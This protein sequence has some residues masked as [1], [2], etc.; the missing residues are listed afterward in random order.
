MKEGIFQQEARLDLLKRVLQAAALYE[1]AGAVKESDAYNH[2]A[3]PW[4]ALG[5]WRMF[6]EIR[7]VVYEY[8][9]EARRLALWQDR[10]DNGAWNVQVD[11]GPAEKITCAF[12]NEGF[13]LLRQGNAQTHAYVQRNEREMQV[14]LGGY[15]YRL[16]RRRP[17]DVNTAGHGG[18]AGHAQEA[19]TAPMAG[20][21]VK[22]QVKEGDTVE[23]R[24]VLVILS[25]MKMEHTIVAPYKG[26]VSRIHYTEGDVVQGGA[27]IVEME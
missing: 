18:G 26:K 14:A 17:P 24:Q 12:D 8:Q 10:E 11:D 16:G 23:Q 19:L 13:V 27:V 4:L 2:H 15:I 6:G 21:I 3:N 22:V 9:G 20:T 5:P 1:V 7:H 25:A